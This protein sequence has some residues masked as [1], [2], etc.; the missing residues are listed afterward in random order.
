CL[1][2]KNYEIIMV[3]NASTDASVE[4]VKS[5]Y[6]K[7]KILQLKDNIGFAEANNIGFELSRGDY[8]FL[9]NNDTR[10][11]PACLSHLVEALD[12]DPG[13]G[14]AG[15]KIRFWTKFITVELIVPSSVPVL[16]DV[17]CL[18]KVSPEYPKFF[19]QQGFSAPFIHNGKEVR[20]LSGKA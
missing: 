13:L 12:N 14:G 15:P 19:F 9:L 20:R 8:L 7:V 6:P 16:L 18:R 11:D 1:T 10:C 3:D 5:N 2:Y 4:F 17:D